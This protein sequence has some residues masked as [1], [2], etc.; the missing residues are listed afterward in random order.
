MPV[1]SDFSKEFPK[2]RGV[3]VTGSSCGV[4]EEAWDQVASCKVVLQRCVG[5]GCEAKDGSNNW[6]H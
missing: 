2:N 3:I 1:V 4:L 5:A 6:I